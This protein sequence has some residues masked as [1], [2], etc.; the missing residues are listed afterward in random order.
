V[1]D[2]ISVVGFDDIT[3][4]AH[5]HPALT[6]V[7]QDA[8]AWGRAATRAVFDLVEHGADDDVELAPARLVVR[9]STAPAPSGGGELRACRSQRSTR[10]GPTRRTS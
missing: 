2:E 10:S 3:V 9:E 7:A 5:M 6:T 4:A 8:V 1:P